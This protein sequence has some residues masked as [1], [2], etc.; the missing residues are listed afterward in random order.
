VTAA[1]ELAELSNRAWSA[2]LEAQPL[3]ATAL[4]YTEYDAMLTD[5]APAAAAAHER[6]L[7]DLRR[8][9]EAVPGEWLNPTDRVTRSA[10]LS[11]LDTELALQLPRYPYWNVDPMAGAQ[12][13]LPGAG[14]SQPLGDPGRR[15]D[16]VARWRAMPAYLEQ[17]V[18]NLRAAR[19]EDLVA[20]AA[21]VRRAIGQIDGLLT[22]PVDDSPLLELGQADSVQWTDDERSAFLAELESVVAGQVLPAFAR[23][24]GVLHD[25]IL[26]AARPDDR[27]GLSHL[28]GGSELYRRAV[29]GFTTLDLTPQQV[30]EI[31]LREVARCDAELTELGARELGGVDLADTLHRLR[32]APSTRF[33]TADEI[34]TVAGELVARAEAA[35]GGWFGLRHERPCLVRP[36]PAYEEQAWPFTYYRTPSPDG[37]R[38]GVFYVNTYAPE[39][40]ARF[41]MVAEVCHEAVPGHHLQVT[42]ALRLTGLP[43]F[44]RLG[45]APAYIEGWGLYAERLGEDMGLYRTDLDRLG[46]RSKDALRSC[47]LVVDTGLHAFDWSRQ[48]AIDYLVAHTA[49]GP[50]T[51]AAEVDRYLS[52]P[53]QALAYKLGQLELLSLREEARCRLGAGFDIRRFHDVVLGSGGLPLDT[54]RELVTMELA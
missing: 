23:L 4:G 34:L 47:R 39:T 30:H 33:S 43:E 10:L 45:L 31:G 35:V 28:P 49:Y 1:D 51:A 5:I 13:L 36:A 20:A 24:R 50:D 7:R 22:V 25:E 19:A 26:P 21:L 15:A 8:R 53:G 3:E 42:V 52:W 41:D 46:A 14:E 12:V 48:Q 17:F 6:K 18:A 9:A 2:F 44:R 29:R 16:A 40:R 11:Y 32:T 27:A 54:L 38:P 37:G